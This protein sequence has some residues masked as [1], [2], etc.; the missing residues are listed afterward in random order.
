MGSGW[1]AER[2]IKGGATPTTVEQS[3]ITGQHS[4]SSFR[5]GQGAFDSTYQSCTATEFMGCGYSTASAH[6]PC[7][8][9]KSYSLRISFSHRLL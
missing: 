8:G 7:Y 2:N 3:R 6:K 9:R 4:L 1:P 5:M